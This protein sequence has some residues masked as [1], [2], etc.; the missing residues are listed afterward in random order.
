[1]NTRD[2]ESKRGQAD[3]PS[4]R[5]DAKIE[6]LADWR[7]AALARIRG[8]I[9]QADPDVAEEWKWAKATS[10]GSPV[11]SHDGGIF[12]GETS[13]NVAVALNASSG[14]RRVRKPRE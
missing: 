9:K 8:L 1:V 3:S 7:G 10:P 11:R 14:V 6:E 2:S 12:T 4:D 13:K 5:V